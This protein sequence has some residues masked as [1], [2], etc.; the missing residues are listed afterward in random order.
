MEY[1]EGI[2][3]ETYSAQHSLGQARAARVFFARFARPFP[4]RTRISSIHRD[5]KPAN[6][7]VTAEGEP[8]LLDFGIAR[9]LD[10]RNGG[11]KRPNRHDNSRDDSQLREPG[12][13]A[14]RPPHDSQ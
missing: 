6:I 8:K 3:L 10:P 5:L 7:R 11:D 9:L 4:T 2:P 13:A 1:V 12:T 14:R